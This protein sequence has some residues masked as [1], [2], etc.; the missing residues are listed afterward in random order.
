M[1]NLFRVKRQSSDNNTPTDAG[2]DNVICL[3]S[4]ARLSL[5]C[6]ATSVEKIQTFCEEWQ[7]L[8][9]QHNEHNGRKCD[10]ADCRVQF[11]QSHDK[12][13]DIAPAAVI[14]PTRTSR[15]PSNEDQGRG[16]KFC[17]DQQQVT[18]PRATRCS[19][20]QFSEMDGG[21]RGGGPGSRAPRVAVR[22][23]K[24]QQTNLTALQPTN[25]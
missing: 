14:K 19:P 11:K 17:S 4:T 10:P 1:K 21:V 6:H 13:W 20:K 24:Q 23:P 12:L 25:L 3:R 7:T 5:C 2:V 18:S 9:M 22:S 15:M 16:E 8:A